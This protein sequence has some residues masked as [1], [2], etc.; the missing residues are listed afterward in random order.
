MATDADYA[1]L[2]RRLTSTPVITGGTAVLVLEEALRTENTAIALDAS[3]SGFFTNI[4]GDAGRAK[5]RGEIE[6]ALNDARRAAPL[7]PFDRDRVIRL[8]TGAMSDLV[9]VGEAAGALDSMST[10][11]WLQVLD[12]ITS[13]SKII[14]DLKSLPANVK[15]LKNAPGLL[16]DTPAGEVLNPALDLLGSIWKTIKEYIGYIVIAIVIGIGIAVVIVVVT[17]ATP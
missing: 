8:A 6:A 1:A 10:D 12:H 2:S 13:P 4:P 5:R 3:A 14:D 16:Q 7:A 15:D 17:K 9:Q 11:A